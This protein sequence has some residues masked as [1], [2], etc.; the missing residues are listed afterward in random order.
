MDVPAIRG[1]HDAYH[2][3]ADADRRDIV[4]LWALSDRDD[5]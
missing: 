4:A 5:K 1:L 3:S 2:S